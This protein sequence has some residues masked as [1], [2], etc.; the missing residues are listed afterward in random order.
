M[1]MVETEFPEFSESELQVF[2]EGFL[3]FDTDHNG[4]LQVFELHMMYESIGETKVC[5]NTR[6]Y[7]VYQRHSLAFDLLFV[8]CVVRRPNERARERGRSISSHYIC[9]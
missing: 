7:R 2:R 4:F 6:L 3:K 1:R 9:F 8:L 5:K